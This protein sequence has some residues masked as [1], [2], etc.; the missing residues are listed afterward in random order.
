M[1]KTFRIE[2]GL[3]FSYKNRI[4]EVDQFIGPANVR[5]INI[6]NGETDIKEKE[7]LLKALVRKELQI[8]IDINE[9]KKKNGVD[10]S[11]FDLAKVPTELQKNVLKNYEYIKTVR[12]KGRF[13]LVVEAFQQIVA[14]TAQRIQD[15]NPPSAIT[16]YR[17]WT[18]YKK[19]EDVRVLI[20]NN[21]YKG[22]FDSRISEIQEKIV[23][24]AIQNYYLTDQRPTIRAV[25]DLIDIRISEENNV[26]GIDKMPP[27][28]YKAVYNRIKKLDPYVVAKSRYNEKYAEQKFGVSGGGP[29]PTRI[30]QRVE[31]DH[32]KMDL[33]VIC[34]KTGMVYGR[35]WLTLCID[36]YS[37]CILG[38][39]ISFE[40]PSAMTALACLEH[41]IWPK[42]I[43]EKYSDIVNEWSAAGIP[44]NLIFDNGKEFMGTNVE[45]ACLS[46]GINV[47]YCPVQEP[48]YK[49]CVERFFGSINTQL[50]HLLPGTSFSNIFEKGEYDSIKN[51]VITHAMLDWLVAKWIADIYHQQF[52]TGA[53]AVPALLWQKSAEKYEPRYASSAD[54]LNALLGY[55]GE[56]SVGKAGIQLEKLYYSCPEIAHLRTIKTETGKFEIKYNPKDLGTIQVFDPSRSKWLMVPAVD[57]SYANGLTVW[58][59]RV[60]RR[61]ALQ[62]YGNED[63]ESLVKA[64]KVIFDAVGD[65][66]QKIN[67]TGIGQ[68]IARYLKLGIDNIVFSDDEQMTKNVKQ[69]KNKKDKC[70]MKDMIQATSNHPLH[71]VSDVGIAVSATPPFVDE[72]KNLVNHKDSPKENNHMQE[73][74]ENEQ[75]E[76]DFE[77]EEGF[78]T[79]NELAC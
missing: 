35:P 34:E 48:W 63:R 61:Y 42:N 19:S 50:I 64:K 31:M 45:N 47:D 15:D 65:A 59:H 49:G 58:Q 8:I 52:H 55:S 69:E 51:A 54:K 72:T 67:K 39:F 10:L 73:V 75:M 38:Y 14:E 32:T 24:A 66:S 43:K 79:T 78:I 3:K 26:E 11:K 60:H 40:P 44:E 41:A 21:W 16:V 2:K 22:N 5:I 76:D 1:G 6:A 29:R 68:K 57:F 27:I 17:W 23:D 71:G 37:R 25:K 4:W 9:R 74:A 33:F 18:Q 30:L 77:M 62:E 56:R 36:V 12:K 20:D 46:L 70:E 7:E 28:S 13:P 53:R